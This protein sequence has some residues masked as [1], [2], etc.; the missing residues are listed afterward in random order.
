MR[1][2]EGPGIMVGVGKVLMAGDIHGNTEH[3]LALLQ[4][5]AR[6]DCARMFVLGDFGAW[7]HT[8]G[9]K[10]YFDVVDRAARKLRVQVYFLDGNHDKSSLVR[11]MYGGKT[12][13]D[14][15]LVCRKNIRYAPRGHRWVW[16]GTSFVAFG[17]AYSVDKLWRLAKEALRE[18]NAQR[19]R[20][21]GSTRERMTAET[22]WFPEEEMTDDEFEEL[23]AQD[24]SPVD[25]LLSHDKPA[26]AD[27]EVNRKNYAECLPNQER[28]QRAVQTLRPALLLHGHLHYRYTDTISCGADAQTRV[29]GLGADP[30]AMVD[31]ADSTDS[32][33]VLSLPLEP[34]IAAAEE[35]SELA[36]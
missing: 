29:E 16:D 11:E 20:L 5:A 33:L 4:V 17:G 14:G 8:V 1:L 25:V 12:D 35:L 28:I 23:L 13:D 15:F 3:A 7:E 31:G 26:A 32:W 2:S 34:H 6:Q 22:L 36:G 30:E 19:H 18:R 9:G 27:P 10:Q 21:F 24:D